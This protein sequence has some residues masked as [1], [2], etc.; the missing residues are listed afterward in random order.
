MMDYE[1]LRIYVDDQYIQSIVDDAILSLLPVLFS[2]NLIQPFDFGDVS[3]LSLFEFKKIE[4]DNVYD[5]LLAKM[6]GLIG[7]CDISFDDLKS[8]TEFFFLTCTW[9]STI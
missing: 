6:N 5:Q 3:R 4:K 8:Q 2:S 1:E 7:H 9:C